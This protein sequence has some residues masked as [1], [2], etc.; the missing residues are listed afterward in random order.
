MNF[1]WRVLPYNLKLELKS[2]GACSVSESL[3]F[4][5]IEETAAVKDHLGDIRLDGAICDGFTNLGG[6]GDIRSLGCQRGF[7]SRSGNDGF[8][9]VI[10]DEL[11]VNFLVGKV[12]R[13]V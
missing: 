5:V 3:D 4:A 12:N 6:G 13:E 10:I 7:C 9:F 2:L 8:A 1:C 11:G